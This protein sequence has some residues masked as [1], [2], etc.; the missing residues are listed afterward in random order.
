MV[1]NWRVQLC[2][3]H[4]HN[5]GLILSIHMKLQNA[6][7]W[8]SFSSI[9]DSFNSDNI[10]T[11]QKPACGEGS[12]CMDKHWNWFLFLGTGLHNTSLMTILIFKREY[13]DQRSKHTNP[14]KLPETHH[15]LT[16]RWLMGHSDSW[17]H[18]FPMLEGTL[19][20]RCQSSWQKPC[21]VS[22]VWRN[23]CKLP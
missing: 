15:W 1:R 2:F 12:V 23:T 21:M 13:G 9:A 6:A 11:C 19:S 10:L 14:W 8:L 17:K 7:V 22:T 20:R 18:I 5:I 4:L 3:L 16:V